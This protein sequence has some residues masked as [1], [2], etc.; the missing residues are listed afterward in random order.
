[1][2]LSEALPSGSQYLKAVDLPERSALDLTIDKVKVEE[3]DDG[4]GTK[5]EKPVLYFGGKEKGIVLNKTNGET[6]ISNYGD[7]TDAYPG[8]PIVL[9]RSET[10]FQGKLVP[11]LR[12]RV[13]S[14]GDDG[15][16]PKNV[17]F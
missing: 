8:E 3:I 15:P 17:T 9:F 7:D 6:L 13:P 1:M 4:N 2:R 11:C 12:I 16:A 14:V 10:Q 5:Q